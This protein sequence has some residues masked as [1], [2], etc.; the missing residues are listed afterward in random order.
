MI[1][2]LVAHPYPDRSR[3]NRAF[4][5]AIEGLDGVELCS[6]YD[7][8]PDFSIDVE[9]EQEALVAAK[10][11][12]WQHPIYW[13]SVPALLKLWFERVLALGFAFGPGGTQLQGKHCLWVTTTGAHAEAYAPGAMHGHRF[14]AFVP[15][16]SQTARFCGMHWHEP[17]ILHGAHRI[18]DEE[19]VLAAEGYRDR[20]VA[21]RSELGGVHA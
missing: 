12:V 18:S 19:L 7:R 14:E 1:R 15:M 16:V 17:I 8:Y 3:A 13:Y 6:L 9:R 10:A 11:V 2:V 5:R 4:M 20:L 21:L